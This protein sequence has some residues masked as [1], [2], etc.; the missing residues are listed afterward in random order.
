MSK[1]GTQALTRSSSTISTEASLGAG[2]L[3]MSAANPS[4]I[5]SAAMC[6]RHR[7]SAKRL[8]ERLRRSSR[9]ALLALI[10]C[11][12]ASAL[13]PLTPLTLWLCLLLGMAALVAYAAL[14]WRL[15]GLQEKGA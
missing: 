1:T 12:V 6:H 8:K 14:L 15:D 5:S 9:I 10:L 11:Q 2:A 7:Q 3:A 13:L 4:E